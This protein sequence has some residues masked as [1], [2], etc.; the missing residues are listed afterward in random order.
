[1]PNS[2]HILIVDD[3][4]TNQ[5]ILER[6][7][8]RADYRTSSVSSGGEAL[9]FV[10]RQAPDL[11]LLDIMM[12]D[13]DGYSV[14][15]AIRATAGLPFIP[16]MFVTAKHS[17]ADTVT[18]LDSGADDYLSKPVNRD[19]LLARV[20]VLLRL[21]DSRRALQ[22]EREHLS[23][24][25]R[26]AQTLHRSLDVDQVLAET[27]HT[28]GEVLGAT[29][30]S[31]L[32][33]DDEGRVWRRILFRPNL[34]P[35]EADEAVRTVLRDGL[36]AHA[37]Q[38]NQI[39]I[40]A[41]AANDERWQKL[42]NDDAVAG[43][44][45]AMPLRSHHSEHSVGVLVLF[46]PRTGYFDR[47]IE[48]LVSALSDQI[49]VALSNASL[50]TR[51][52][53]AEDSRDSFIQMLTHDLRSP[54]AGMI[55]CFDALATTPLNE[56]G[57]Y[58]VELGFRAGAVQRRL[59]DDLLDVYKAEAGRL[60]L[61]LD[62]VT[63]SRLGEL[64]AEVVDGSAL[65][66]GLALA[67]DLPHEP[68]AL[69]DENKM[70]RVIC[71]LVSNGIKWTP[72]GGTVRVSGGVSAADGWVELV[73]ADSGRGIAPDDLDHIF[74]KFYQGRAHSSVRGTGLGLTFCALV[75]EAHGG[76]IK[77]TSTLGAGTTMTIRIPW[78]A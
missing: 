12:P 26:I 46:N 47:D 55:G 28:I 37:L 52:R 33:L 23:L 59:I 60:T 13:M 77:A 24:L 53:E 54:L 5:M 9:E 21:K 6:I 18:G 68:P 50:Y 22:R 38:K 32:L 67:I 41:D 66:A 70:T 14:L 48:P 15:Q 62:T 64:V 43:S 20:R 69:L 1:M 65:E 76:T 19:E 78:K 57:R 8:E 17:T 49:S 25:Y 40:V 35:A 36:A 75:V 27:L 31:V 74:E 71:N 39:Q 61:D 3:Q 11:I 42:P 44:A 72:R 2:D 10:R 34:P 7:L 4:K 58:F 63:L 16:I 45:L 56:D 51:L 73:V 30:G 29:K